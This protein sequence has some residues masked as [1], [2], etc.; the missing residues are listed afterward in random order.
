MPSGRSCTGAQLERCCPCKAEAERQACAA[1]RV[2]SLWVGVIPSL[3]L[4]TARAPCRA[5]PQ[6]FP[7]LWA[8]VLKGFLSQPTAPLAMLPAQSFVPHMGLLGALCWV[9]A[10]PGA[11][12][13]MGVTGTRLRCRSTFIARIT[14]QRNDAKPCAASAPTVRARPLQRCAGSVLV[15]VA[16]MDPATPGSH[17]LVPSL[18][19]LGHRVPM[20]PGRCCVE[21]KEKL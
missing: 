11:G 18:H 3:A 1:G 8:G 19:T 7:L 9:P 5:K 14:L 16:G 6:P 12:E 21:T 17:G 2:S 15:D 13:D 4:S 10:P 20:V